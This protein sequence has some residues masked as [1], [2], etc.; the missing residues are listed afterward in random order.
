MPAI[1]QIYVDVIPVPDRHRSVNAGAVKALAD[2]MAKIGLRT[3]ITLRAIGETNVE[4]VAGAHRLAA[5][6]ELGWEKIDCIVLDCTEVEA[7][8]WEIAENLHR[9]DL[10]ALQRDEHIARWIEL[11][12]AKVLARPGPKPGRPAS[13]VRLAARELGIPKT[14]AQSAVKVSNLTQEA[15][16]TAR[17]VGLDDNRR[18]MLEAAKQPPDRQAEYLRKRVLPK[19]WEEVEEEQKRRLMSAWNAASPAVKA[20]F[21]DE[22]DEPVMDRRFGT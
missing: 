8:M 7:E 2:S 15:K 18:A 1:E 14:T 19:E 9:A 3:P 16:D 6:K 17:E 21:K 20:W 5:A 12:K 10:T 22:I 11:A 13:G 4:L